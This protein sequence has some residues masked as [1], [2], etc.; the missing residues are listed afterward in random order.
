VEHELRDALSSIGESPADGTD[1]TEL[2]HLALER[3]LITRL[4]LNAVEGI[5]VMRN[6]ALHGPQ[7]EITRTQVDEYLVL[8]EGVLYTLRQNIKR[9]RQ[10]SRS[11]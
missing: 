2:A 5:L 9:Y 3:S 8:V 11:E 7:R 4:T 6:L 10:S 1:A